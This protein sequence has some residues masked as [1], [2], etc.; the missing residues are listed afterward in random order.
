MMRRQWPTV[1]TA[2]RGTL[3]SL[4]ASTRISLV[5]VS[6]MVAGFI[7]TLA[8]AQSPVPGS[9]SGSV[10]GP[11][12]SDSSVIDR[13]SGFDAARIAAVA[14]WLGQP[15]DQAKLGEAAKL[16]FQVN[17]L[18]RTA[19]AT[20]NAVP[21]ETLPADHKTG[22]AVSVGGRAISLAV[23]KLPVDL[24]DVLDFDRVYRVEVE[25]TID[26]RPSSRKCF[27][28]S[29]TV[30]TAW[31]SLWSRTRM[32]DQPMAAAGLVI[33]AGDDARPLVIASPGLAWF[34]VAESGGDA[35]DDW[36]VLA[37]H[38]FNVSLID[39]IKSQ[40]RKPLMPSD[41]DA[42]YAMLVAAG[43]SSGETLSPPS[44]VDAADLLRRPGDWVGRRLR[45][46][47][48]TVRITRVMVTNPAVRES[49]ASDHYWQIDALGELG[50]V[51]IRIEPEDGV[52]EPATFENRFPV[53]IVTLNLPEFIR[54]AID[55]SGEAFA[56]NDVLMLS[57]QLIVDGF[58]YRLWSY[59]SDLMR[60]HGGG[61]QF[62]PLVMASRMVDNE[63]PRGDVIG[64]GIIGQSAA[65]ATLLMMAAAGLWIYWTGRQDARVRARRS[66]EPAKVDWGQ[67]GEMAVQPDK[68]K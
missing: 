32:L 16:L 49:I 52:S 13:I 57:R 62:G 41:H 63:P 17:R 33:A 1:G 24:A 19:L 38:G 23:A 56:R 4:R 11:V 9:V 51:V 59:E 47:C 7:A 43:R 68:D 34:P 15:A 65:V 21:T 10:A 27:V 28:L 55:P 37:R 35:S 12:P 39:P 58:F 20:P 42:F 6:I 66:H 2:G 31:L 8:Q 5:S 40:N 30:P 67:A 61:D 54:K 50:N 18:S 53:S 44:E 22:D 64:V 29:T 45:L 46:R 36:A 14:D 48:Q 26:G 3:V 25:L 60:R